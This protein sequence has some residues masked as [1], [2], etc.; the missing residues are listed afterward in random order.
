MATHCIEM[1][2]WPVYSPDMNII[3]HLWN[4]LKRKLRNQPD[5]PKIIR[6]LQ[7]VFSEEYEN[8]SKNAFKMCPVAWRSKVF[9]SSYWYFWKQY[10]ILKYFPNFS[11]SHFFHYFML[12][13]DNCNNWYLFPLGI[14]A[15]DYNAFILKF[16]GLFLC[17]SVYKYNFKMEGKI[18]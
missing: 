4:E 10:P 3:E 12:I 7:N 15:D 6:N 11:F 2:E 5:Q 18:S 17:R 14:N 13:C 1:I 16:I 8:I 9:A